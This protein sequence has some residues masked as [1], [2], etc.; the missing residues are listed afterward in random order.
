M[1]TMTSSA[2]SKI[3]SHAKEPK[4]VEQ[5]TLQ[6]FLRKKAEVFKDALGIFHAAEQTHGKD[7]MQASVPNEWKVIQ[8]KTADKWVQTES[9]E[10]RI[11]YPASSKSSSHSTHSS[12]SLVMQA[13]V[14]VSTQSVDAYYIGEHMEEIFTQTDNSVSP[15]ASLVMQASVPSEWQANGESIHQFR[16]SLKEKIED[17]VQTTWSSS[18]EP[19]EPESVEMQKSVGE[20]RSELTT[21]SGSTDDPA[22][23]WPGTPC[24]PA[25]PVTPA[26]V[27]ERSEEAEEEKRKTVQNF[28]LSVQAQL[29]HY[30]HQREREGVAARRRPN[31]AAGVGDMAG[32][33]RQGAQ[34]TTSNATISKGSGPG[35]H[36]CNPDSSERTF[37]AAGQS[38]SEVVHQVN[39]GVLSPH[40]ASSSLSPCPLFGLDTQNVESPALSPRGTAGLGCLAFSSRALPPNVPVP[41][42]L[43]SASGIRSPRAP[44]RDVHQTSTGIV[45][46]LLN[47]RNPMSPVLDSRNLLHQTPSE[48]FSASM[49]HPPQFLTLTPRGVVIRTVPEGIHN[50]VGKGAV[51][52]NLHSDTKP[53]KKYQLFQK[54]LHPSHDEI[55]GKQW[56]VRLHRSHLLLCQGT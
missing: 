37:V 28:A 9:A 38:S 21:E 55:W 11:Q 47:S 50:A 35:V 40:S 44:H 54:F 12:L 43:A 56:H 27:H 3:C 42:G 7:A 41:S 48:T 19:C 22:S 31:P 24:F 29:L 18:L 52:C 39:A 53:L 4:A 49:S 45:S 26:M 10:Q 51:E 25:S 5:C 32:F 36:H 17:A 13:S 23:S 16:P 30:C 20:P 15:I 1:H 46:P 14:G 2:V 6:D 34:P 8:S 33:D